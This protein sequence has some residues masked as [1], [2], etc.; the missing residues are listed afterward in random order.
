MSQAATTQRF[1]RDT[2]NRPA[3]TVSGSNRRRVRF[4]LATLLVAM[5]LFAILAALIAYPL[6]CHERD[7]EIEMSLGPYANSVGW[8]YTA[9]AWLPEAFRPTFLSRLTQLELL[10]NQDTFDRGSTPSASV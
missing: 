6:R 9:P 5:T 7:K 1:N 2:A 10:L 3:D 4:G 8:Q